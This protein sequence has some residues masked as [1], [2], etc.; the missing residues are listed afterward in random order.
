LT[1]AVGGARVSFASTSIAQLISG[2]RAGTITALDVAHECVRR[3]EALDGKYR[4]WTCFDAERL[5]RQASEVDERIRSGAEIRPLEGIPIGVKDIFNTADFPTQMGSPIWKGFTP[6]NDARVVFNLKREGALVPG[7]T[8][9][10]EFAVH[11]LGETRN[12][13]DESRTPGTSSSGSAVAIALGMVPAALGTQTAGSIVRPASFCGIYGCKPSFGLIPRTGSLK[14]TD[15]LDTI[16]YFVARA[17][18]LVRVFEALR[19]H[20][21]DYPISDA[22]LNDAQ[23]Q[24]KRGSK[25]R[26]GLVR[27]HVWD[28]A[29]VYARDAMLAWSHALG[30]QPDVELEDLEL[31]A[32]MAAAHDVHATIYDRTLAYYFK[33]EFTMHELVSPIMNE[34]IRHGQQI[35]VAEYEHALRDQERLAAA[36]DEVLGKY[37][38]IVSLSTSGTAPLRDERE[39]PDP[40]LMWTMTHLPVVSVPLFVSPDGLPFGAQ[41]AARR[42]SDYLLF[43]FLDALRERQLIP[44]GGSPPV[45]SEVRAAA[46]HDTAHVR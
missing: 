9:T 28:L 36:M 43:R 4:V 10:A 45:P 14:T 27:T 16:G 19:V 32:E 25:W 41:F 13:H 34:I 18:D 42:Y 24:N 21:L 39:I 2:Y 40:S 38:V 8:E 30:S 7:K 31:P 46:A 6:G 37:D 5:L 12:P 29:P 23:R 22:A 3:V 20:G 11:T 26:V 35:S 44:E 15:S 1:S 33:N 17:E